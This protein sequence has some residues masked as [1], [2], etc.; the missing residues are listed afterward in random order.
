MSLELFF[1]SAATIAVHGFV[2]YLMMGSP[3]SLRQFWQLS[4]KG[5]YTIDRDIHQGW[6]PHREE[7]R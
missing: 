3:R 5:Q 1:W 2:I 4:P 7:A 6:P